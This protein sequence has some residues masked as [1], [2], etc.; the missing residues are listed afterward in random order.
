MKLGDK[1]GFTLSD[2]VEFYQEEIK[3]PTNNFKLGTQ[4][5]LLESL[6][7]YNII[8]YGEKVVE[9]KNADLKLVVNKPNDCNKD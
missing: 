7:V 3:S 9:T 6:K 5:L 4:Q 8:A 2:L 1:V